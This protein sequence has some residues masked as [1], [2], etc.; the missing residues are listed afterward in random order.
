MVRSAIARASQYT[1]DIEFSAEDASRTD[2]E[3]LC[4]V[5]RMAIGSGATT[6]NLPDTVGYATPA[7]Y[8]A[9][10]RLVQA[11]VPESAGVVLSAHCHDDL[12]LAVANILRPSRQG[13]G[14]WNAPLTASVSGRVT[15]PWRSWSW[16][17]GCAERL[18]SSNA[19]WIPERSTAPAS[20]CP[21]SLVSFHAKQGHRGPQ[22][23]CSRGRNPPARHAPERF[24]LRDHPSRDGGYSA[25]YSGAGETLGPACAGAAI[26]GAGVP[27]LRRPSWRRSTKVSLRWRNE[28]GRSWMKTC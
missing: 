23:L 17:A 11:Q 21:S 1:D 7:E 18:S 28:S 20:C 14:R 12:G 8:A 27:A 9:M 5:I 2:P 24:D 22:R 4:Q 13:P 16:P 3:F 25:V 26:P 15:P 6:I 19:R 10:F